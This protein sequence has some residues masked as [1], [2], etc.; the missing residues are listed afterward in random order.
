[1]RMRSALIVGMAGAV[2]AL[3][4]CGGDD[5]TPSTLP[6]ATGGASESGSATDS[7]T[8]SVT[9]DPT[10][11]LQAELEAFFREY[12][13]AI[14]ASTE[15]RDAADKR[16]SFYASSCS[17]CVQGQR[18]VDDILD[19]SRQVRGGET[20]LKRLSVTGAPESNE[21]RAQA[22]F[23]VA[24]AE[25]IANGTVVESYDA[26]QDYAVIFTVRRQPSGEWLITQGE[27]L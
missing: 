6:S 16:R 10:A 14:N 25:V 9:A 20:V 26:S 7:E 12:T 3:S 21:V 4:G 19:Q 22:A 13:D 27:G 5:D 24:Q 8:P 15:S 11:A 23:D 17:I 18:I 1:M 2:L